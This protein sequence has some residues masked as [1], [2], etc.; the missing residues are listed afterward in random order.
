MISSAPNQC[1]FSQSDNRY[2]QL[3]SIA[4]VTSYSDLNEKVVIKFPT[5][6]LDFMSELISLGSIH[7]V[8]K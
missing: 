4:S 5:K 2:Y 8:E 3:L 7:C 6:I 1:L